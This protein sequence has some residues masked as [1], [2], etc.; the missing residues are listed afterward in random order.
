MYHVLT[1]CDN[2]FV[3]SCLVKLYLEL[4]STHLHDMT[5]LSKFGKWLLLRFGDMPTK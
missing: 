3:S 1:F 5:A 2:D 4:T